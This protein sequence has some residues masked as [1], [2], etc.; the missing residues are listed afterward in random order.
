MESCAVV[1]PWKPW[2]QATKYCD[3][4]PVS[5]LRWEQRV[6]PMAELEQEFFRAWAIWFPPGMDFMTYGEATEEER[7]QIE[8]PSWKAKDGLTPQERNVV[9][10]E[11]IQEHGTREQKITAD[12][13]AKALGCSKRAALN[14]PAW[15]TYNAGWEEQFGKCRTRNGK[16]RRPT[17]VQGDASFLMDEK[18]ISDEM[19]RLAEEQARD[20]ASD[21]IASYDRI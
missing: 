19:Q 12:E 5:L 20:D 3:L 6:D 7:E 8:P 9:I 15:K 16:G 14:S 17:V 4:F 21:H 18:S 13:I 11:Y 10:R 1:D 2:K